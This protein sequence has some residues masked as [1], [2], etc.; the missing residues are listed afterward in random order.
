MSD[1]TDQSNSALR[2]GSARLVRDRV[3]RRAA[4]CPPLPRCSHCACG[5]APVAPHP[6]LPGSGFVAALFGATD[7]TGAVMWTP[8]P[9]ATIPGSAPLVLAVPTAAVV[10]SSDR[11]IALLRGRCDGFSA[12]RQL[13]Q[14]TAV[15]HRIRRLREADEGFYHGRQHRQESH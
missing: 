2:T 5:P 8:V 14:A 13:A 11:C 3:L 10:W 4:P 1:M 15:D 9:A 6:R 12:G 7:P